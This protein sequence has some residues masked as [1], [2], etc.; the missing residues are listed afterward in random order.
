MS[1]KPYTLQDIEKVHTEHSNFDIKYWTAADIE[2]QLPGNQMDTLV[3]AINDLQSKLVGRQEQYK[4]VRNQR[5]DLTKKLQAMTAQYNAMKSLRESEVADLKRNIKKLE[6]SLHET[7]TSKDYQLKKDEKDEA[8]DN[9]QYVAHYK[10]L[11]E[12]YRDAVNFIKESNIFLM[13]SRHNP[14]EA[15]EMIVSYL[16]ELI[17]TYTL[18]S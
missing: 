1:N 18:R 12:G 6:K 5:D 10:A 4:K 17:K 2:K 14:V 9:E 13:A 11:Y 3:Q 8:A 15:Q 16:E 7:R